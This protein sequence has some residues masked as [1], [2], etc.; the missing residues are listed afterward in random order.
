[1]YI[2]YDVSNGQACTTSPDS[3]ILV[4]GAISACVG[5]FNGGMFDN[6]TISLCASG[7]S[8]CANQTEMA[9]MGLTHEICSFGNSN[10]AQ[11]LFLSQ[12]G[13]LGWNCDIPTVPNTASVF[14]CGGGS[15]IH[16]ATNCGVLADV[17]STTYQIGYPG[18]M[19]AT[20]DNDNL[21]TV[22]NNGNSRSGVL[23]CK[24]ARNY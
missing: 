4:K 6:S 19:G 22:F 13:G 14:G 23:C 7:Y 20:D 12:V 8:I 11:M 9:S 24:N 18:D 1:M 15:Y 2:V 10:D 21:H 17:G 3:H 5:D 16:D